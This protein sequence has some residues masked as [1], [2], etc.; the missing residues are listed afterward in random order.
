MSLIQEEKF[1]LAASVRLDL[2]DTPLHICLTTMN[3]V[4]EGIEAEDH[5]SVQIGD[6]LF[7]LDAP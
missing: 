1:E 3:E 2:A 6:V 7:V 4:P 5:A